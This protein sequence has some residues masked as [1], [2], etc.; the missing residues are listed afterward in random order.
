MQKL[1]SFIR[2]TLFCSL[3]LSRDQEPTTKVS[4]TEDDVM[5]LRKSYL[6][7]EPVFIEPLIVQ[8]KKVDP[9]F[10]SAGSSGR[11]NSGKSSVDPALGRVKPSE[12]TCGSVDEDN[13]S[14]PS[15]N[16]NVMWLW[17]T[18]PGA[19][20]RSLA[21]QLHVYHYRFVA[22]QSPTSTKRNNVDIVAHASPSLLLEIQDALLR[23]GFWYN[24]ETTDSTGRLG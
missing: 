22:Q 4:E 10:S 1:N 7:E 14:K 11:S 15:Y 9:D 16:G 18:T 24:G 12:G 8:E 5:S 19:L 2:Q 20:R 13:L 17:K 3:E 6:V 21:F 23:K